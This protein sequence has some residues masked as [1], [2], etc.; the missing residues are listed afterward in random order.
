MIYIYVF[1]KG[2]GET[3]EKKKKVKDFFFDGVLCVSEGKRELREKKKKK[4]RGLI[5]VVFSFPLDI[6]FLARSQS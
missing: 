1:A 3:R 6:F 5:A 2:E 4:R